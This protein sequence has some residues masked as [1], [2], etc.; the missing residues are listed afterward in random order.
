MLGSS[1]KYMWHFPYFFIKR[2]F[3]IMHLENLEEKIIKIDNERI[4]V[5]LAK[6]T[7]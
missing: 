7:N 5:F 4:L 2:K 3:K 6:K 1:K